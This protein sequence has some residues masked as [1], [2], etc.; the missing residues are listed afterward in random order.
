MQ[1]YCTNRH[2]ISAAVVPSAI[3]EKTGALNHCGKAAVRT[4]SSLGMLQAWMCPGSRC[5]PGLIR[6]V[7]FIT[8]FATPPPLHSP[9][10]RKTS[11]AVKYIWI[12]CLYL[13]CFR[14]QTGAGKGR[15]IHI[16]TNATLKEQ[17]D[18]YR[19]EC[20]Q[21][22]TPFYCKRKLNYIRLLHNSLIH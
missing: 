9:P 6:Y 1:E 14:E 19:E 16:I 22:N 10:L 8:T 4:L 13:G 3:W 5:L 21:F 2:I 15:S 20:P 11:C 7:E 12:F 17:R 18:F